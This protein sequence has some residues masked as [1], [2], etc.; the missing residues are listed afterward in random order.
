[1]EPLATKRFWKFAFGFLLLVSL[2]I[3]GA[4]LAGVYGSKATPAAPSLQN[5]SA[6]P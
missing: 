6:K 5:E 4:F 2:G 3:T 1:M